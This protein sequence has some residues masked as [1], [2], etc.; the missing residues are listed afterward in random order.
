MIQQ[1]EM[2]NTMHRFRFFPLSNEGTKR[3]GRNLMH[4]FTKFVYKWMQR[5]ATRQEIEKQITTYFAGYY[6]LRFSFGH[7][8]F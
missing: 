4:F 5:I 6:S 7:G 8:A 1:W 2:L 3:K